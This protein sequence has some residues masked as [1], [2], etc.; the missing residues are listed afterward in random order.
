MP[1][2]GVT[3]RLSIR[4][5]HMK[6]MRDFVVLRSSLEHIKIN[7]MRPKLLKRWNTMN[8]LIATQPNAARARCRTVL[9]AVIIAVTTFAGLSTAQN[10]A[11]QTQPATREETIAARQAEKTKVLRPPAPD[12]AEALV[13]KVEKLLLLDP[14][15]LYPY[16][17]SVYQGGGLTLG[18]GYRRFFGDNTFWNVQGLYSFTNYKLIEGG[19]VSKDHFNKKLNV[20]TRLGWRDA[21]QVNFF[22]LGTNSELSNRTVYRFQEMYADANAELRLAPWIPIKGKVSYEQ[23]DTKQGTG[24]NPSIETIFNPQTAPGLGADPKY[25]HSTASAGFDWRQSPGYSRRGGLYEATLHDFHNLQGGP[26]SF[27]KLDLEAIQY[28][29]IFRETWV[30][31]ARGRVETTLNDSDVIPYFMLP[32]L[33]GGSTLRAFESWRFRDRHS[34]LMNAELRWIP[35]A[36]LDMAVFYDAG[37][38]TSRRNDLNFQKLKSDVG[39]G[40]RIHGLFSTPLRVDFAI[41][42]EG[43]RIVFSG[44]PVF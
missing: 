33:G 24:S 34:M 35:A 9:S 29:P 25:L 11:A 10:V 19:I 27:R 39:V 7:P 6:A 44:G 15:G 42:N 43:W 40:A 4:D 23:W 18:A 12:K 26:Y 28:V 17:D 31:A 5:Q 20:S 13:E 22:G 16:F 36:G 3:A 1:L 8:G 21:T 32:S 37:K 38:V 41:G 14:S 30:F 2:D